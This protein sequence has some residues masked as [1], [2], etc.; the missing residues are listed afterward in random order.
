MTGIKASNALVSMIYQKQLRTNTATNKKFNLGEMVNFVQVD[1]QKVFYLSQYLPAVMRLPLL[2]LVCFGLLFY[3]LGNSFW[4]GIGIFVF[5][6]VTNVQ[7]ARIGGRLQKKYMKLVDDRVNCTTEALNNIKMLK[8][9][10]WSDIFW[11]LIASKRL[12]ELKVLWTRN[13]LG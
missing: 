13:T 9:Y 6:F 10:S 5:T 11:D 12:T 1:A 2:I 4:A 8:L 7:L 3:Y